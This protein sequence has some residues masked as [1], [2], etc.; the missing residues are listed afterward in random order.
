M[1]LL[2]L[3]W[4]FNIFVFSKYV[5]AILIAARTVAEASK[6]I[7]KRIFHTR[8]SV[9]FALREIGFWRWPHP[10]AQIR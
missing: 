6:P 1:T 5:T 2:I 4:A 8:L 3:E 10:V 9:H 7:D